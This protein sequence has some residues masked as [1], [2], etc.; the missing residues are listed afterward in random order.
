M[1]YLI[2]LTAALSLFYIVL[3][4]FYIYSWRKINYTVDSLA[5]TNELNF[6]FVT[7]LIAARNEEEHIVQCV[8]S[9]LN[10]NYPPSKF[11][12][13]VVDDQSEDATYELL[14]KEF[15]QSNFRLMRLGVYRRTTI[16]GSKK[17]AISYGVSHAQGDIIVQTD[18]DCI[19]SSKWLSS[20]VTKLIQ[21][22]YDLVTGP[23]Q[24]KEEF[25][26]L[27][28]FQS[29]DFM[30]SCI[31]NAAGIQSRLHELG[32]GANI[33]FKKAVFLAH[34]GFEG[35]ESIASG[36]DVFLMQKIAAKSKDKIAFNKSKDAIV[37]TYGLPTLRSFFSQRLRWAGKMKHLFTF[38]ILIILNIVF[39]QRIALA[40][41][42]IVGILLKSSI[43]IYVAAGC[44][45]LR[46][47]VDFWLH[48]E[49]STF[50]NN[51][52]ILPWSMPMNI[53]YSIYF[54]V[55]SI[56]SMLPISIEWKDRKI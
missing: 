22:D 34:S 18:A 2:I 24:I 21:N 53:L 4:L 25:G 11:E 38:P 17:K 8:T 56:L 52:S 33:A 48:L 55:L 1:I 43:L 15:T 40:A 44:L 39:W 49:A 31:M 32:N 37:T 28:K 26:L 29:L 47:L 23:V 12:V 50:F 16:R 41:L 14:E 19:V 51:K 9:C 36:D 35:N 6:P 7:I 20:M 10:Q 54:V 27:N 13:I 42:F 5:A 30:S 46:W 3:I 45:L